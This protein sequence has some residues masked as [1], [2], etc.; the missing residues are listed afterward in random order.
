MQRV[1]LV[2]IL[3]VS[4]TQWPHVNMGV[5]GMAKIP[6]LPGVIFCLPYFRV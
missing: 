4:V 1:Y 6:T 3:A 2:Q 5:Y